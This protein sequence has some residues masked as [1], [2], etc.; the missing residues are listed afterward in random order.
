VTTSRVVARLPATAGTYNVYMQYK[1][2]KNALHED[3][4]LYT[5]R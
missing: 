2:T 3:A 4:A 1:D 5:V